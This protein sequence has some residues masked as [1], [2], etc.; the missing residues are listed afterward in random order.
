[1]LTLFQARISFGISSMAF[2]LCSILDKRDLLDR[3]N[4]PCMREYIYMTSNVL[5]N[6]VSLVDVALDLLSHT[7]TLYSQTVLDTLSEL[8]LGALVRLRQQLLNAMLPRQL[9]EL[10]L[11]PL[12]IDRVLPSSGDGVLVES[13]G[14][15]PLLLE[16]RRRRAGSDER[17]GRPAGEEA[18][19]RLWQSLC[20]LDGI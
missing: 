11:P 8:V 18:L 5:C 14:V 6:H 15:R 10:H 19:Q 16:R 9:H 20:E 1:M 13:E 12:G 17:C 4:P 3:L 7:S 2:L